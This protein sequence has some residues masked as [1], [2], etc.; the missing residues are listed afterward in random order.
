MLNN[1]LAFPPPSLAFQGIKVLISRPVQL[2]HR[3]IQPL[4]QA[5]AEVVN[6][7]W[8]AIVPCERTAEKRQVVMDL[9]LY[10][11][12]IVISPSAA[13]QW[14]DFAEDYWPQW[15]LG[16]Q[17]FTVGAGT[18]EYLAAAGLSVHY[19]LTGDTSEDLLALPEFQSVAGEKI[20][21]VKGQGGRNKLEPGLS[22]LGARVTCLT[23][24]QRQALTWT[25]HQ[26]QQL[27]AGAFDYWMVTNGEA[28]ALC[29]TQLKMQPTA[30]GIPTALRLIVPSERIHQE[31]LRQGWQQVVNAEGA[32]AEAMLTALLLSCSGRAE[33]AALK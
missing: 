25:A 32:G 12:V 17:W 19:P 15:P 29:S 18:A 14:L 31:A 8:Q 33:W 24:Y 11:K 5:G 10:T 6:W 7:P 28:L 22:Q 13:Q 4:H 16:V 21:L 27:A 30:L 26:L 20:L 9:D 3:L 1:R 2:A 23:L